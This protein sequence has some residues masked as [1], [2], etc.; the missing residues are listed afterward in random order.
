MATAAASYRNPQPELTLE[1]KSRT[2]SRTQRP[3]TPGQVAR[4]LHELIELGFLE[5]FKDEFN[6]TRFRPV[7]GKGSR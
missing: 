2:H 7:Y 3:L 4:T 5:K 1:V 6:V